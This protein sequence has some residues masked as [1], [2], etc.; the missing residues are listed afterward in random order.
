MKIC[1]N[2]FFH[3]LR[4]NLK[5]SNRWQLIYDRIFRR[6]LPLTHYIWKNRLFIVCNPSLGDHR[7]LQECLCDRA[8]DGLLDKCCFPSERITYVNIGANIGAFDFLFVD[9]NLFVEDG[10]AVE[11][12]PLTYLRCLLNFQT[13]GLTSIQ[14]VNAGVAGEG[15]KF[16]FSP[17][18]NSRSDSIFATTGSSQNQKSGI[19]VKLLTLEDLLNQ[20]SNRKGEF[21]LLKLDCESAEYG[22]IRLSSIDVL[23]RFRHIIIEFHTEPENES[24]QAAYTKLKQA[25]FSSVRTQPGKFLFTDLFIRNENSGS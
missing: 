2:D 3:G 1:L 22:I 8:Y 11:L 23:Q 10:L 20:H 6:N 14:L 9:R 25:G 4:S 15:G 16:N 7:S 13:N 5:F 12:N 21:D 17:S 24:V 19:E 18:S